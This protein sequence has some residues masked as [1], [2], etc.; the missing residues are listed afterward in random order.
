MAILYGDEEH[1]LE[2]AGFDKLLR[3]KTVVEEERRARDWQ[4]KDQRDQEERQERLRIQRITASG[5]EPLVYSL[6][7]IIR[8]CVTH[9]AE[10]SVQ[11][12][13][14]DLGFQNNFEGSI[15][16]KTFLQQLQK[17]GGFESLKDY[18]GSAHI[19]FYLQRPN[20]SK[21][22]AYRKKLLIDLPAVQ[23]SVTQPLGKVR[24]LVCGKLTV[25]LG[26]GT[27]QYGGH[28][29]LEI[30][31]ETQ[32]IKMLKLL[33]EKQPDTVTYEELALALDLLAQ[34]PETKMIG[35]KEIQ[36]SPHRRYGRA[37]QSIRRALAKL[38][39]AA[40][41]SVK[42]INDLI[43]TKPKHGFALRCGDMKNTA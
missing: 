15:K 27:I 5:K 9:K 19:I 23:A 25:N 33:V 21:L 3:K 10:E 11:V 32:P 41:M 37:I 28:K 29:V 39:R 12:D 4:I 7:G 42:E 8:E 26:E 24:P 35:A 34:E 22:K 16:A 38:L 17:A 1:T 40:G 31:V 36:V 43:I 2:D 13:F 14:L 18:H 20:L 30:S 6:D